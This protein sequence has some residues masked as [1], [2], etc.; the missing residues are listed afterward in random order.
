MGR[1]PRAEYEAK[2]ISKR[3]YKMLV[4]IYQR[5]IDTYRSN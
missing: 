2:Y 3:N 1:A 5:V 4:E